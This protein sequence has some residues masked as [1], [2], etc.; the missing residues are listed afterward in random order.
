MRSMPQISTLLLETVELHVT[1]LFGLGFSHDQVKSMC[2]QQPALLAYNYS[3]DVRVAKWGFLTCVLQLSHDHI[4]SR[5]HLLM[6]SLPNRMGPRW[7]YLLQ[8]RLH[9]LIA[10]N[11]AH[12]VVSSLVSMTDSQFR[13]VNTKPQLH[14][15]DEFFRKHWHRRWDFLVV[16]E[17]L[18]IQDI[19][20]NPEQLRIPLKQTKDT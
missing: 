9:G 17:Q 16:H 13:A 6:S 15:Y 20:D 11:G 1:Q 5:P 3:S 14:V 18:S 10:F 7:E 8:L 2:L 4:V 12:E 19:A